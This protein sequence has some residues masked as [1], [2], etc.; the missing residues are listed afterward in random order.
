M[1]LPA[2]LRDS[3]LS[4]LQAVTREG[5]L[6]VLLLDDVTRRV[7]SRCCRLSDVM[8][9][10]NITLVEQLHAPSAQRAPPG[11]AGSLNAVYLVAPSERSVIAI[12]RDLAGRQPLY[13]GK[14]HVLLTSAAPAHLRETLEA[15]MRQGALTSFR[16]CAAVEAM[17]LQARAFSLDSPSALS[18]LYGPATAEE[19]LL[20]GL[21]ESGATPRALAVAHAAEQIG[22]LCALLGDPTPSVRCRVRDHPVAKELAL[23]L[24][25]LPPAATEGVSAGAGTARRNVSVLVLERSSD[26]ITPLVHD[27]SLEALAEAAGVLSEGRFRRAAAADGAASEVLLVH[28]D[29]LWDEL[30]FRPVDEVEEALHERTRTFVADNALVAEARQRLGRGEQLSTREMVEVNRRLASLA[31]RKRE[32]RLK[33]ADELRDALMALLLP[34]E[35]LAPAG[36][37]AS[38]RAAET[39]LYRL[40]MLEQD[41]AVGRDGVSG[42]PLKPADALLRIAEQLRQPHTVRSPHA[43]GP[44]VPGAAAAAIAPAV[45]SGAGAASGSEAAA[46]AP[47]AAAAERQR[48]LLLQ[49]LTLP[50]ADSVRVQLSRSSGL[51]PE[52]A[53]ALQRA[54][55]YLGARPGRRSAAPKPPPPP[56]TTVLARHTPALK[57]VIEAAL[58]PPQQQPSAQQPQFVWLR[59]RVSEPGDQRSGAAGAE[60]GGAAARPVGSWALRSKPGSEKRGR[61]VLLVFML[62]G[63]SHAEVRCAHEAAAGGC[64]VVFG[65]TAVLTPA[66]FVQSLVRTEP[67]PPLALAPTDEW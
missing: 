38:L 39:P 22:K 25:A 8:G 24:L 2:L 37:K 58:L 7:L 51:D 20:P 29:A 41:L 57:G 17:A 56:G 63:A 33:V 50:L 62:G 49:A 14:R 11:M 23:A 30:R 13:R 40:M 16:Q 6:T 66:Q 26:L 55:F 34:P 59:R 47:E 53:E 3:V 64:D 27:F 60:A 18:R 65:S 43:A 44:A 21:D 28:S 10:A 5:E 9:E 46:E 19:H 36:S 35:E 48:L 61:P 4:A 31:Y 54:L 32:E 1:D 67:M 15:L 12:V 52:R 45:V 42:Y